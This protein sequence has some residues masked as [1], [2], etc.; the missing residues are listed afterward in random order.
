MTTFLLI[1]HGMTDAVGQVMT[2]RAPGLLLNT[3]GIT[4]VATLPERLAGMPL[5]A[6]YASPLERTVATAQV[7]ADARGLS[8]QIEPRVTEIDYGG[9]TGLRYDAMAPD[10]AWQLYNGVRSVARPPGGEMLIDVQQRAVSALLDMHARHPRQTVA[11]VSHGDVLRAI[12]Q[13]FLGMPIDFVLRLEL[14]PGR[15]SILQLGRGAPRVLQV[16]GD[17]ASPVE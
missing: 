14:S 11:V 9:W 16:N 1:R 7:L 4:H 17:T 5:D 2:G 8:L 10:P 6:V 12:L 3:V 13:Y 15:I